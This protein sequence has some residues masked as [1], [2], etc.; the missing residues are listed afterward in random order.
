[1]DRMNNF[2]RKQ[3]SPRA[4]VFAT[5][6][7]L[8]WLLVAQYG[9]LS[10]IVEYHNAI[11]SNRLRGARVLYSW[12]SFTIGGTRDETLIGT[13]PCH[14]SSCLPPDPAFPGCVTESAQCVPPWT[15]AS[16]MPTVLLSAPH[17]G[18]PRQYVTELPTPSHPSDNSW[19]TATVTRDGDQ[20]YVSW[21][22]LCITTGGLLVYRSTSI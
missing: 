9:K 3:Q 6:I 17:G 10:V 21:R 19:C 22:L 1:M 5:C 18:Y 4:R 13:L 15:P 12:S 16:E 7:L 8:F 14:A 11:A 20:T 2:N